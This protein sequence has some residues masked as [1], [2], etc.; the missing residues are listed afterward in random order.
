LDVPTRSGKVVEPARIG[1]VEIWQYYL[2]GQT[3]LP[4]NLSD[5]A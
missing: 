2:A 3:V 5:I 1:E 4:D